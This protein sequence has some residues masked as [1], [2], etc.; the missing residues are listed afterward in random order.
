[1][2][3]N[4]FIFDLFGW[5]S[6]FWKAFQRLTRTRLRPIFCIEKVNAQI[7]YYFVK[8]IFIVSPPTPMLLNTANAI[9]GGSLAKFTYSFLHLKQR[10][11]SKHC[12]WSITDGCSYLRSTSSLWVS[13]HDII[14]AL[15][16]RHMK[17]LRHA[18]L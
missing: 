9:Y 4:I 2:A 3:E 1:M 6:P 5:E 18:L 13:L 15:F 16:F 17:P 11:V 8:K 7:V 14:L 10:R 12:Q